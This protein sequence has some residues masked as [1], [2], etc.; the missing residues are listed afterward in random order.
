MESK[1]EKAT[2][3]QWETCDFDIPMQLVD[4]ENW[5]KRHS[6]D[7]LKTFAEEFNFDSFSISADLESCDDFAQFSKFQDNRMLTAEQYQEHFGGA[8]KKP[9][10]RGFKSKRRG[11]KVKSHIYNKKSA[12]VDVT[13]PIKTEMQGTWES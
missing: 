5:G 6:L 4:I 10:P 9:W 3:G 13:S 2:K 7:Q 8:E 12:E 1:Q 11:R